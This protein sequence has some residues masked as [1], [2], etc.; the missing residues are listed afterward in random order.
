MSADDLV[1]MRWLDEQYLK[2]P[3]YGSRRMVAVMRREGFAEYVNDFETVWFDIYN[4]FSDLTVGGLIHTSVGLFAGIGALFT[5][6]CGLSWNAW[7]R[8]SLRAA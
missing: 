3:F 4:R 8:V 2:T 6:R 1:L 7:Q 5:K